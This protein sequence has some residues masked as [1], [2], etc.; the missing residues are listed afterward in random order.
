VLFN[1]RRYLVNSITQL[2]AVSISSL[3]F[4][5]WAGELT[6]D[7]S[8]NSTANVSE[9]SRASGNIDSHALTVQPQLVSI[10]K[11][12]KANGAFSINHRQIYQG[13][14]LGSS[15]LNY[16]NYA[17]NSRVNLIER[18]LNISFNANQGY[19]TTIGGDSFVSDQLLSQENLAKTNNY[20]TNLSF[21]LPNPKIIGL[22]WQALYG[23]SKSDKTFDNQ[24]K[25]NSENKS[26][27]V[28]LFSGQDLNRMKFQLSGRKTN[29]TRADSQDFES[30]LLN[31]SVEFGIIDDFSFVVLGNDN[32]YKFNSETV[33]TNQKRINSTSYGGGLKWSPRDTRFIE[34]TYNNFEQ[35]NKITKYVGLN[36]DW[37]FSPRTSATFNYGKRFYGDTY[38]ASLNYNLK[39]FKTSFSYSENI[40][41]YSRLS[42]SFETIGIF[43]CPI[44][45][46]E[47]SEC[48]QVED[49]TYVLDAGEEFRSLNDLIMD[50]TDEVILNKVGRL[51]FGYSLR[52]MKI[53]VGITQSEIEYLESQRLQKNQGI[54][55]DVNYR[56]GKRVDL[57]LITKYT[58]QDNTFNG[59]KG[60]DD[61]LSFTT[62]L[63]RKLSENATLKTSFRYVNRSSLTEARD[64]ID[65]RLTVGFNYTF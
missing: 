51:S 43:V 13:G 58:E 22:N 26:L 2:V 21:S 57:G 40:T 7:K 41:S 10:Y 28:N 54:S 4:A 3:S 5:T 59:T 56:L 24:N 18:M 32:N 48:S 39:A 23:R 53:G 62:T 31:G 12:T 25:L 35:D 36:A 50:I 9:T 29:T 46:I 47:F 65:K 38:S 60:N 8:I 63:N 30:T 27:N 37:M 15:S 42:Y 49:L 44:G 16:T 1:T 34:V 64:I 61:T 11:S 33:N 55:L 45:S 52:K 14:D 6:F 17:L 20:S 19:Q